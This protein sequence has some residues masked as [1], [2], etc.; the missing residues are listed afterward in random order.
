MADK[1]EGD[2]EISDNSEEKK[3]TFQKVTRRKRKKDET[4]DMVTSGEA[5]RPSFPPLAGEKLAV[6]LE[7]N[8]IY[9]LILVTAR[10]K[11]ICNDISIK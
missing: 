4:E 9:L 8:L 5:K 3:E 10:G 2:C 11:T 7:K 6:K 1:D